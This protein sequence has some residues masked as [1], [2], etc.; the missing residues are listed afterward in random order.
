MPSQNLDVVPVKRE[1]G[2]WWLWLMDYASALLCVLRPWEC[3]TAIIKILQVVASCHPKTMNTKQAICFGYRRTMCFAV[4]SECI[5]R[6]YNK[7][8]SRLFLRRVDKY[9]IARC[10]I[11]TT[12]IRGLNSTISI[13]YHRRHQERM[14]ITTAVNCNDSTQATQHFS[15][16]AGKASSSSLSSSQSTRPDD[17]SWYDE[18]KFLLLLLQRLMMGLGIVHCFTNYVMDITLCSGPSMLPTIKD[19]NEIILIDRFAIFKG[20]IQDGT[21][22]SSRTRAALLRREQE[23]LTASEDNNMW[24]AIRMGVGDFPDDQ[25]RQQ[26]S[27]PWSSFVTTWRNIIEHM[28]SPISVGDVVIS[29]NPNRPGTIC[30]RILGLPGDQVIAFPGRAGTNSGTNIQIVPDHHVWLEGDN[31]NNSLDSRQSGP[32]PLALLRGRAVARIWPI[33]G[34]AYLHRTISP[35]TTTTYNDAGSSQCCSNSIVIPAGHS[36]QLIFGPI[37]NDQQHIHRP[38][39]T[40]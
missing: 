18:L 1:F 15:E 29:Q 27:N 38:H 16:A 9:V 8:Y 6:A 21:T 5:L 34:N 26:P 36:S 37:Q 23:T 20:S 40:D 7:Y 30:K 31:A 11:N 32:I 4:R 3:Q 10:N 33:R 24:N 28:I 25:Q 19:S 17:P 35:P 14:F 13:G 12:Y 39:D 2:G 22:I